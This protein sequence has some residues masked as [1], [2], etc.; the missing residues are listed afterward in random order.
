[1]NEL[2]DDLERA[3]REL[4]A[5]AARRADRVDAERVAARVAARLRAEPARGTRFAARPWALPLARRWVGLAAA[6]LVLLFA[7]SMARSLLRPGVPAI[8]PVPVVSQALDSLDEQGLE[9]LLRV[10]GE[11]RPSTAEPVRMSVSGTWDDLSET[12]LRAVL[13]AVQQSEETKL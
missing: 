7:G 3:L 5:L 13:Q 10:T 8:V 4:D 1:M 6:A 11:V 2:P 12:Q 9:R